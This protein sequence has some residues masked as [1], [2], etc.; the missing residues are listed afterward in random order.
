MNTLSSVS[1]KSG[2][3]HLNGNGRISRSLAN[4]FF[5]RYGLGLAH[6]EALPRPAGDYVAA[7]E[8]CM[9]GDFAAL[10][11]YFVLLLATQKPI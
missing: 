9:T 8:R 2:A 3:L 7:M 6:F 1:K 5:V 4:Y 11:Q 10:Y